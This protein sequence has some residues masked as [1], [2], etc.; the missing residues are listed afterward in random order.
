MVVVVVVVVVRLLNFGR[1]SSYN[2]QQILHY[3]YQLA[4]LR[5][6]ARLYVFCCMC[7]KSNKS[8]SKATRY[9]DGL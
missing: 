4:N 8:E 3:I 5:L 6:D 7:N 2:V 1:P 9:I